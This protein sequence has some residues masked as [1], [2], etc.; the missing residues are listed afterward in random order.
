ML[1]ATSGLKIAAVLSEGA[2]LGIRDP[3]LFLLTAR[4]TFFLAAI[5]ELAVAAAVMTR[6]TDTLGAAVVAWLCCVFMTYKIGL[7]ATDGGHRCNCL[8]AISAWLS[9]RDRLGEYISMALLAYLALPAAWLVA[10]SRTVHYRKAFPCLWLCILAVWSLVGLAQADSPETHGPYEVKGRASWYRAS[11]AGVISPEPARS[12]S[13]WVWADGGR[14]WVKLVRDNAGEEFDP[15]FGNGAYKSF[16]EDYEVA[17]CDGAFSYLVKSSESVKQ[18]LPRLENAGEAWRMPGQSPVHAS[19]DMVAVWSTYASACYLRQRGDPFVEFARQNLPN[20]PF[21][22]R[23]PMSAR[24]S[25]MREPPWLPEMLDISFDTNWFSGGQPGTASVFSTRS[26]L[27]VESTT[28]VHG[29][30]LPLSTTVA[31]FVPWPQPDGTFSRR[32]QGVLVVDT[33]GA[34]ATPLVPGRI[35]PAVPQP[36]LLSESRTTAQGSWASVVVRTN[37]WPSS[38]LR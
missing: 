15:G 29:L 5:V 17:A 9:E 30:R 37:R 18:R 12:M 22:A 16:V 14:W 1:V 27:R 38:P 23:P 36:V 25:L 21:G 26:A 31:S 10:R 28:N 33:V 34:S 11:S 13:F 19:A 4:Q 24:W 32:L 35:P 20:V 6:R 2:A 3:V 7:L 8:G